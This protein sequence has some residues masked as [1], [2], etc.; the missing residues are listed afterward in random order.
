MIKKKKSFYAVIMAGG[1][2]TRLWPLSRKQKPKQFQKFTSDKTM[3]QETYDRVVDVVPREN[4]FICTADAY[5]ELTLEQLPR[6]KREQLILEPMPR[7]TASAIALAAKFISRINPRAVVATVASDHVIKNVDE[8]HKS[9]FAALCAAEKNVKKL[10][11]VGIN[12]T[13]P[14]TGLGY[15]KMGKEFGVIGGKKVFFADSFVEKPDKKTA[16]K[17][18]AK[19]EYLWNA[20]YFVFSAHDFLHMVKKHIP[21]TLDILEKI[22]KEWDKKIADRRKIEELYALSGNDPIDTA[23]AE[24]L[25]KKER[26]VVP[27]EM[28]WSDVGNWGSLFDFLNVDAKSSIVVRGRH[29]DSGSADCFVHSE[30]K[31]IATVGLKNIVIIE[32][33]DAILVADKDSAGEVKKIIEK[34]KESN[35]SYL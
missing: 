3:I 26:L 31:L 10:V 11:I 9:L 6:I 8:F 24:K 18:L 17:Y 22:G 33:D 7:G 29:I 5:A 20:G 21:Q 4:I 15:I 27:S 25:D 13:C 32:S 16:E 1:T 2:G 34:L 35:K 30:H 14:D 23:I 12:P 19:W 28:Q